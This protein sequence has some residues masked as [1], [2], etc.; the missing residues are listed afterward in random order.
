MPYRYRILGLV[1]SLVVVMYLDRLCISVAGPRIQSDLHF[2]TT[3]WGWVIGA[4]TLAYAA[5]EVPSGM[6]ADRIGPRRVITR[7]VLWWSTFT[8]ATGLAGGLRSMLIVRFLFGAGEAGAF[9]STA[10]VISRWIPAAERGRCNSVIW[11]SSGLGGILTP[12]LVVPIQQA[13]GWRAAFFL[14]GA[15]GIIWSVFWYAKFRDSPHEVA[16]VSKQERDAIGYHPQASHV[17]VSWRHLLRQRNYI[18]LL[19]MYHCYCWGGY[20]Y[21]SWLPTYLQM[22]RGLTEDAMKIAAS[23]TSATGMLGTIA[24]GFLSDALVRRAGLRAGRCFPAAAGLIL[25]G[26]LLG[27]TAFTTNN[28]FAVAGLCLGLASMNFML[29]VTWALCV[30]LGRKHAGSVTGSMNMA[31]QIGSFIS[32]VAF[33]YLVKWLGNYNDALVPLAAMLV[34]SGLLYLG[35]NPAKPLFTESEPQVPSGAAGAELAQMS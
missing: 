23:L 5:F 15:V 9:P 25:S 20:F 30:D 33:G 16:A 8:F 6:L 4:F 13:F 18:L 27:T 24:G 12:L 19:C 3:D 29:P 17:G 10:A 22:G 35:I 11:I 2:S 26:L 7:I 31:G 14:F 1:S 28:I 21:L 34:L 32:S